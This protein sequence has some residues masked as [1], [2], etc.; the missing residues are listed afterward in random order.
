MIRKYQIA[1]LYAL[2]LLA[3]IAARLFNANFLTTLI[4]FWGVP[5]LL[6]TFWAKD[7]ALKAVLFAGV[8]TIILTGLDIIFWANR[9]W[10]VESQFKSALLG[11]VAWEDIPY[12]F[13]FV[14]FPVIFWEHFHD[15]NRVEP[16]WSRR[17]TGFLG[18]TVIAFL[19]ISAAWLWFPKIILIPYFYL[20][21]MLACGIIPLA[22]EL[23]E[24]P[25]LGVKFLRVGLYFAYVA[26]LV[27]SGTLR[28]F[29][30]DIAVR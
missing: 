7:K 12:W 27:F 11:L 20:V 15:R 21:F 2:P 18:A 8:A 26:I 17:M 19:A 4:L 6:L 30:L 13:L 22:L 23:W 14:Y 29:S 16:V 28:A 1:A 10:V 24:H 5:S 25:R 9:Q 3:V